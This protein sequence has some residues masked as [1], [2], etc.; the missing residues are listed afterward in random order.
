MSDVPEPEILD[1]AIRRIPDFPKPGV[2]FY[3][4]TGILVQPDAFSYC[5]ERMQ[6]LYAGL[7]LDGVAVVESRG[8]VFGAPFARD[9]RIPL[10]LLRKKGK[11]PGETWQTRFTL[12]YG[13]DVLEVHKSDVSRGMKVLL[14]DD[15]IA[16]GGSL[17]ASVQLLSQ[18]GA[19]VAAIF[20]VIGLPFL[21]YEKALSGHRVTTLIQFSSERA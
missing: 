2:L 15:L 11:L 10:I 21:G 5:I 13:E 8:F 18:G 20:G 16:T 17:R 19:E 1:S 3:D 14:V 4:I 9:R 12:E 6:E 7:P